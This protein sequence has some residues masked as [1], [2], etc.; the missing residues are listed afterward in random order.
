MIKKILLIEMVMVFLLAI[1]ARATDTDTSGTLTALKGAYLGQKPPGY[2]PV[3]F[4]P[5]IVS[6]DDHRERDVTFTSDLKEFYFTRD[7]TIMVMKQTDQ[8]WTTATPVSFSADYFEF[9]AFVAPGDQTL[10]YISNRSLSGEGPAE[11]YQMWMVKRRGKGWGEPKRLND[12]GDFYP[13]ITRDGIMYFTSKD[14]DLY[15]TRLVDGRMS[16]RERLG[17]S[18]NTS[19]GEYNSCIAPDES[20]LI[21]TSLGWGDGFG[22]GDLWISFRKPNGTWSRPKN[23]G[24]GINSNAHEY[25]P[26]ISPDGKYLFFASNLS[27]ADD[28]LWVDVGI[29]ERLKKED[30]NTADMLFDA[31]VGDGIQAGMEKYVGMKARYSDCCIFDGRLLASVADRLIRAGRVDDAAVLIRQSF[32]LYPQTVTLT[33]TLKLTVISPD[34]QSFEKVADELRQTGP[35]LTTADEADI[36]RLGY[37]FMGWDR[38]D[39]AVRILGLNAELFPNS[40]NVFDSY[41]E[42][43][44]VSGDTTAAVENYRKSLELNPDNTNAATVLEQLGAN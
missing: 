11:D 18:V 14:N 42:A 37:R 1:G 6:T 28:I 12:Q 26:A 38:I 40:F 13:T 16:E 39:D 35:V 41:G 8:G 7:A 4:V 36:N 32:D 22:G 19:R 25:C 21:F 9:E 24:G 29:I 43:L 30:L 20:F 23:M 17:D 33:Q 34:K 10:Y 31:V 15:R 5:G 27:G 44:L 2:L 3:L